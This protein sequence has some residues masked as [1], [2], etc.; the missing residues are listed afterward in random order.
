MAAAL[1]KRSI[2]TQYEYQTGG[3]RVRYTTADRQALFVAERMHSE[4]LAG[5]LFY[6]LLLLLMMTTSESVFLREHPSTHIEH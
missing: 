4:V 2:R 1:H 6:Y 5:L 3:G